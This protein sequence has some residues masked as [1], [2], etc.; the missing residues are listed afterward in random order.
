[1]SLD[2]RSNAVLSSDCEIRPSLDVST[3]ENTDAAW[4]VS[5]SVELADDSSSSMEM[6]PLASVSVFWNNV[7]RS[8]V[9]D[10][11]ESAET[12]ITRRHRASR[13][14]RATHDRYSSTQA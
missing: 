14:R 3:L 9:D 10:E 1:M 4:D 2:M 6:P 13:R 11:E 12:L 8:W 7:C 5:V